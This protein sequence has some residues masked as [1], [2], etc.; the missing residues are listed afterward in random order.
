MS[1]RTFFSNS[2]NARKTTVHEL[3][4]EACNSLLSDLGWHILFL[5][6]HMTTFYDVVL[7]RENRMQFNISLSMAAVG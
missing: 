2:A 1:E 3:P 7:S 4:G 5:F 6:F